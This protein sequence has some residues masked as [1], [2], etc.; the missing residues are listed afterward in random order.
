[1]DMLF[2]RRIAKS[3]GLKIKP[4]GQKKVQCRQKNIVIIVKI[5]Y[6]IDK[7]EILIQRRIYYGEKIIY[8]R[9]SNRRASGQN[10]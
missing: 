10:V 6:V 9:I 4:T 1:M 7:Y 2:H 8:L 5:F 3:F